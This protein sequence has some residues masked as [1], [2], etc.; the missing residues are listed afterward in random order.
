MVFG[1]LVDS[2]AVNAVGAAVT[3]IDHRRFIPTHQNR[4]QRGAHAVKFLKLGRL[5]VNREVRQLYRAAEHLIH[6]V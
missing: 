5:I 3:H 4:H 2:R 1:N 6:P